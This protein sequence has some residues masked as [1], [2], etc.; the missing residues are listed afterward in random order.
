MSRGTNSQ[1]CAALRNIH[2]L[3]NQLLQR[4]KSAFPNPSPSR[5]LVSFKA[6][7]SKPAYRRYRFNDAFILFD[8]IFTWFAM[9][10]TKVQ[11]L[12]R[13]QE[14]ERRCFQRVRRGLMLTASNC[15]LL[16]MK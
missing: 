16:G 11:S 1:Q 12:T 5:A 8:G 6:N 7:T 14:L 3:D 2:R 4:F 15:F 9:K 13:S 10:R